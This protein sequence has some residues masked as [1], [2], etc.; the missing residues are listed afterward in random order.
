MDNKLNE[1]RRK[2][3]FLRS[4]MLKAEDTIRKQINRDLDLLEER[5]RPRIDACSTVT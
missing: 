1:V 5:L 3:S 2:I 4:E